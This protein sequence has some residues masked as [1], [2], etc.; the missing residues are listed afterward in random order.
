MT[1]PDST[2]FLDI[3][4]NEVIYNTMITQTISYNHSALV[5]ALA[6]QLMVA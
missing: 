2:P 6:L 1:G 4:A 5:M 3:A